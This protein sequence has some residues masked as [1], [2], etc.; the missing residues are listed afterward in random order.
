MRLLRKFPK[1]MPQQRN[2]RRNR[3]HW[4]G[5]LA[6]WRLGEP[7]RWR[8]G[9]WA[10][11]NRR[12]RRCR[13]NNLTRRTV[14]P[15]ESR[16]ESKRK[17]PRVRGCTVKKNRRVNPSRLRRRSNPRSPFPVYGKVSRT[18]CK[19]SWMPSWTVPR[20]KL[21]WAEPPEWRIE[22]KRWPMARASTVRFS[23]FIEIQ[24]LF[25]WEVRTKVF[26]HSN[27]SPMRNRRRGKP[28]KSSFADSIAPTDSTH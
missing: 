24:F 23:R 27:S 11:P 3:R 22:R 10:L 2:P 19:P 13:P 15:K 20:S 25:R 6:R 28:L 16:V 5:D 17:S 9:G 1:E 14:R 12:L 7:A 18:I 21:S 4:R 26:C 8:L